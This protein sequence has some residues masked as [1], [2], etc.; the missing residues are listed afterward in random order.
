M[1]VFDYHENNDGK[2]FNATQ[3][4][5]KP[6]YKDHKYTRRVVALGGGPAKETK[7]KGGAGGKR[8]R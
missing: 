5:L 4:R 6:G 7:R 1:P 3:N 8:G 2:S